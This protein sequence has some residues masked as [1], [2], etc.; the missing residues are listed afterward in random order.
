MYFAIITIQLKLQTNGS[1][2]Q[3][4]ELQTSNGA[5]SPSNPPAASHGD[6][7]GDSLS[8]LMIHQAIHTIE[9]VLSTISHTASYL[10][11]WA[12]S[13]AHAQLSEVLWNMVLRFGLGAEA[14]DWTK[15][16]Y[17]FLAF[18]AWALFT[19]AILVMMEGLSAFLHTLRLHWWEI[20]AF[21]WL[22]FRIKRKISVNLGVRKNWVDFFDWWTLQRWSIITIV[23]DRANDTIFKMV[24]NLICAKWKYHYCQINKSYHLK[25]FWTNISR[26]KNYIYD[27]VHTGIF[28]SQLQNVSRQWSYLH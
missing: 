8:E 23:N 15:S 14:D 22:E 12:L 20:V 3:D 26:H 10:R 27:W 4:I 9:Y 21:W 19:L 28:W 13:L 2:S 7:H 25:K 16:I 1:A 6:S 17:L 24:E 5:A 11:L 18:G